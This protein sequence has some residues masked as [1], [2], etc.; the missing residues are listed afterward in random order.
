MTGCL[1]DAE[2]IV[3]ETVSKCLTYDFDKVKNHR[4]WMAKICTN[5]ALDLLKSAH[6][7][8]TIYIGACLPEMIPDSINNDRSTQSVDKTIDTSE[9][10]TIT[11]LILLQILRPNELAVF[12]LKDVFGYSFKEI[13]ELNGKS[14]TACRKIAERSRASI[15][16]YRNK[17]SKPTIEAEQLIQL[18]FEAAQTG[19]K[20]QLKKLLSEKAG[21]LSDCFV[22]EPATIT[23]LTKEKAFDFFLM[24]KE[25]PIFSTNNY[26]IEI[27]QL[28]LRPDKVFSKVDVGK[29]PQRETITSFEIEGQQIARI[30]AQRNLNIPKT[31]E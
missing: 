16:K 27:T 17:F 3:Q 14:E 5:K 9:S 6:K 11:F 29:Y 20:A 7:K 30:Y 15:S 21:F 10:L 13:S 8:R 18:F 12:I 24:L 31:I 4:A 26:Q 1:M 19:N 2:D 22:K 25:S 23:I 28:N